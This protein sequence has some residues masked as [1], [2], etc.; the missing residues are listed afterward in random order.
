MHPKNHPI[1]E[2]VIIKVQLR[3]HDAELCSLISSAKLSTS[4]ECQVPLST[5]DSSQ[6]N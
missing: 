4:E 6:L 5:P 1:K 2:N 3:K